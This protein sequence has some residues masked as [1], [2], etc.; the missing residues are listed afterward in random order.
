MCYIVNFDGT[1]DEFVVK[2]TADTASEVLAAYEMADFTKYSDTNTSVGDVFYYYTTALNTLGESPSTNTLL[3]ANGNAPSAPTNLVA[4][5][6]ATIG[7][8][9]T[10]SSDPHPNTPVTHYSLERSSDAGANWDSGINV[11]NVVSYSDSNVVAG[12]VYHYRIYAVNVIGTSPASNVDNAQAGVPP[13]V[14]LNFV[15]STGTTTQIA[16]DWDTPSNTGTSAI[17]EYRILKSENGNA[18]TTINCTSSDC[19]TNTPVSYTHLTLPTNRE[20]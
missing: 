15:V 1:M 8:T 5:T 10:A 20:V 6:G 3:G 14:P 12:N 7:L 2:D 16:M 13:T 18:E 4:T 9:W 17:T 11:G 19:L